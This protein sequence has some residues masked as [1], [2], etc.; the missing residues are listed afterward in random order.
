MKF[1]IDSRKSALFFGYL[2]FVVGGFAIIIAII[3]GEIKNTSFIEN[4]EVF[5]VFIIGIVL[6]FFGGIHFGI[7]DIVK[8]I[9]KIKEVKN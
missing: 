1:D 2:L 7:A 5:R 6:F 8:E 3:V 4:E 9:R